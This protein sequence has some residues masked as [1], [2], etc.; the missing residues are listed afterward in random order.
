MKHCHFLPIRGE[1][2]VK[3]LSFF[4][5]FLSFF[6]KIFRN[7]FG[8]FFRYFLKLFQNCFEIF[9]NFFRNF[10]K[11]FSKFFHVFE[12]KCYVV[13][14]FVFFIDSLF[15]ISTGLYRP[16]L[17]L[18]YRQDANCEHDRYNFLT[19]CQCNA[20]IIYNVNLYSI[21]IFRLFIVGFSIWLK[22]ENIKKLRYW[23]DLELQMNFC[24]PRIWI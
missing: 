6:F 2:Y 15:F 4:S 9:S 16:D 17:L 22:K 23:W 1:S 12:K 8:N 14:Y 11:F 7:F 13:D 24:I 10:F 3:R 21:R 5:K 18:A 19:E 20:K